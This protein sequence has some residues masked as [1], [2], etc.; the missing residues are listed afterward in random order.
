MLTHTILTHTVLTVGVLWPALAHGACGGPAPSAAAGPKGLQQPARRETASSRA[1]RLARG[2]R[3][4]PHGT[5]FSVRQLNV[6]AAATAAAPQARPAAARRRR[7]ARLRDGHNRSRAPLAAAAEERNATNVTNRS[8]TNWRTTTWARAAAA[9]RR[10][11]ARLRGVARSPKRAARG[12]ALRAH[13]QVGS[14]KTARHSKHQHPTS[15]GLSS[16]HPRAS[17]R[18]PER[19]L[20]RSTSGWARIKQPCG[21]PNPRRQSV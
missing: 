13:D 11:R 17:P 4:L 3:P 2:L 19:I 14:G 10:C 6:I 5:V 21:P 8:P 18:V 20:V 7:C 12:G 16:Q 9:R 15:L 1:R